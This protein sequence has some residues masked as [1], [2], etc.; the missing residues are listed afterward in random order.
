MSSPKKTI[1]VFR[2]TSI[3]GGSVIKSILSDPVASSRFHIRAV[4]RDVTRPK[5]K[6]LAEQGC[7]LISVGLPPFP[8]PVVLGDTRAVSSLTEA[9]VMV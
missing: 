5:A 1:I 2:A 4:T 7:E 8:C 9:D 3:Q 6:A